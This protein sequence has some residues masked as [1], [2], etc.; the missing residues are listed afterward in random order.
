LTILF[1]TQRGLK[2]ENRTKKTEVG[3]QCKNV[4]IY[5]NFK[6][7]CSVGILFSRTLAKFR[8]AT[9][10]IVLFVCPPSGTTRLPL[11][12][13]S[14]NLVFEYFSKFCLE[15][16]NFNYNL[17]N[18]RDT[19]H[20]DLCIFTIISRLIV[21]KMKNISDKFVETAEHTF[22]VVNFFPKIVLFMT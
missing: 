14:L 13:L 12:G 2:L 1:Q 9:I 18:V 17:T 16:F 8:K 15:K 20:E 5:C 6:R 10:S 21:L 22:Y 11:D 3:V 7:N 19:L 4:T